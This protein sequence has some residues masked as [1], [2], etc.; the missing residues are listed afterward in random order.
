MRKWIWTMSVI[1]LVIQVIMILKP[2]IGPQKTSVTAQII[3][4]VILAIMIGSCIMSYWIEILSIRIGI[5]AL[6]VRLHVNIFSQSEMLKGEEHDGI[7]VFY[8]IILFALVLLNQHM[9]SNMYTQRNSFIFSVLNI[10]VLLIGTTRRVFEEPKLKEHRAKIGVHLILCLVVFPLF[11]YINL[12]LMNLS[13]KQT[14]LA[15]RLSVEMKTV[16]EIQQE[17]SEMLMSLEEGILVV[18]GKAI[19]FSN[20]IF[21]DILK[22]V[23]YKNGQDENTPVLELNILKLYSKAEDT[24]SENSL[25][26]YSRNVKDDLLSLQHL[27]NNNHSLEDKIFKI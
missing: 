6:Q 9:F 14:S 13:R 2:D 23:A 25:S 18:R 16:K 22:A 19:I 21:K 26:K 8:T 11:Y 7:A 24:G 5:L 17:Y 27:L 12:Q 1:F 10:I 4:W 15:A 3:H 20:E